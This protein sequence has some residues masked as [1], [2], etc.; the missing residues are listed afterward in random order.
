MAANLFWVRGRSEVSGIEP[1]WRACASRVLSLRAAVTSVILI[2]ALG[3]F[4]FYNTNVLNDYRTG[5]AEAELS[6][7]Y[8]RRYG[9]YEGIPQP[10]VTGT[11]LHVEIHPKT[12][13]VE[14]RGIYRLE[15]RSAQAIDSVHLFVHPDV[16]TRAVKFDRPA[17]AALAD[18]RLG[19]RIYALTEALQPGGSLQM[20]FEVLFAPRGFPNNGINTSVVGNGTYFDHLGGRQPSH[21]RWLPVIGYQPSRELSDAGLR[22]EHGLAPR[23]AARSLDAFEATRDPA[24]REWIDFEAV[25]GTDEDQTAVAPG[26]LRRTWTENGRRYFHYSTDGPVRNAY[27]FF[28]ADYEVREARWNDVR[29]QIFH[30]PSHG[31]NLDRMVRS[32]R[33]SLDYFTQHFGPYPHREIRI[34]EFPRYASFAHAYPATILYA[35]GFGFLSR[36]DDEKGDLDTPFSVVAHEVAH[37]WWGYQVVPAGVEGAPMLTEILAQYSAMMVMERTHGRDQ[38]R[39]FLA[40]MWIEYLN[41]RN[42]RENREVPLLFLSDQSNLTYRK[43]ALVMYALREYLGEERVNAALRSFLENHRSGEPPYPTSRDLYREL[44]AVTPDALQYLLVD[45][46][47]KITLWDLRAKQAR[48]EP[49]GTGEW[50][51]TLDVVVR[52]VTVD[53]VG[54]ET[55]VPM[56]DWVEIGVFAPAEGERLGEPLHL[57]KHR[58]SAGGQSITVTVPRKPA[59]AGIDP[60]HLLIERDREDNAVEVEME[61]RSR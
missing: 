23:P 1:G 44:Q 25:I 49:T 38:V 34:V 50:R 11:K 13:K 12:R 31:F 26:I 16:E 22:R 9:Q 52:K 27:A 19:H 54:A 59:R 47:E 42:N 28:S 20:S 14:V 8:E 57:E 33:A 3:G 30:H 6:A 61:S 17:R 37:Q 56:D 2:L 7:E 60:Y 55:E 4:V 51:I 21:R 24:G 46:F 39:R 29:I 48:V 15:N 58:L 5:F 32:V 41:R 10:L 35:E 53:S 40:L 45:L 36:V 43:G 18:D